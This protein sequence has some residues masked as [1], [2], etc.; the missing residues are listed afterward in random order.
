MRLHFLSY[1]LAIAAV[2]PAP[3]EPEPM[4]PPEPE[5]PRQWV[6]PPTGAGGRPSGAKLRESRDEVIAAAEAKRA[7][8]AAK[9]LAAS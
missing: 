9:R 7:R 4:L 6:R 8:R 5:P 2:A 1:L 3:P